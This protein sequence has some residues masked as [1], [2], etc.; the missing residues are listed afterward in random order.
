MDEISEA[1]SMMTLFG[2]LLAAVLLAQARA[3][4]SATGEVVDDQ[5]KPVAD[6]QV[7]FY[8]PPVVYGRGDP[9]ELRTTSDALDPALAWKLA[10]VDPAAARR[11]IEGSP[12][13]Q[14]TP[15]VFLF[16]ALGAKARDEAAALDAFQIGVKGIDRLLQDRP[17]RY[18]IRAGKF[19]PVVERIDPAFVPEVF[20]LD[21][22]SRLPAGNPR[23]PRSGSPSRLITYLAWYDRDVAAALF[24]P[25][26]A[27]MERA[28]AADLAAWSI[29]FEAWALFDP[30]AAVARLEKLPV[31]SRV[32]NNASRARLVVAETLARP[33]EERWRKIWD[34]WDIVF[35]GTKRDF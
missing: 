5:G 18:Q 16:V 30:R 6:A 15:H 17:D 26:R 21:V 13:T 8:A 28:D 12:M 32:Q 10:T 20:W 27:R 14:W 22:S 29:E 3:D 33:Y 35:G 1:A 4:R 9:V 24:E 19:L 31:D 2:Q 23:M 11:V 25:T 7:F 34:D